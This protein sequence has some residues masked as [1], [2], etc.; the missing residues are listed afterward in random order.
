MEK[1]ANIRQLEEMVQRDDQ[2]F[3]DM[4]VSPTQLQ[5]Q[6]LQQQQYQQQQQL[7]QQQHQ[8]QQQQQLQQQQQQQQQAT[9][10]LQRIESQLRNV[11]IISIEYFN[12]LI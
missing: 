4:I 12:N 1:Q 7:Q 5:Q 8:Q 9:N 6:Q 10:N 3:R 2:K 11:N